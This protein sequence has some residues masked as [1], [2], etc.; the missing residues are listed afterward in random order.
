MV[1]ILFV[2]S[3]FMFYNLN[4][5]D[6]REVQ[7]ENILVDAVPLLETETLENPDPMTYLVVGDPKPELYGDIYSNIVEL[8]NR[9]GVKYGLRDDVSRMELDPESVILI[10][11]DDQ[12]GRR[13]DPRNL[14]RFI[15]EG[16]RAV[17]A[18][19]LPEGSTDSYLLPVQGII[20][21]TARV[22][23]TDFHFLRD[24]FP[25]QEERMAYDGYNMSTWITVREDATVYV[26]DGEKHTPIVYTYPYGEGE[27]LMINGTLLSDRRCSGFLT[28]GLALMQECFLYPVVGVETVYL[29]NFPLATNADD[30]NCLRLYG[31]TTEAFIRDIIWPAFQGISTRNGIPY[32]SS[33]LAY[34]TVPDS[35]PQI[36]E[37]LFSTMGK[38]AL[39]FNVEL[40]YAS[41]GNGDPELYRHDEFLDRFQSV[42]KKYRVT[43]LITTGADDIPAVADFAGESINM[44]RGSLMSPNPS[45][46]FKLGKSYCVFPRATDGIDLDQGDLLE[47]ASVYSSYGMISHS[48]DINRFVVMDE[49]Q[50]VWDSEKL[51]LQDFEKRVLRV[52]PGLEPMSLSRTVNPLRSY[53]SL[54]YGWW[55]EEKEKDPDEIHLNAKS[56]APGQP[57]MVRLSREIR[58]AQGAD[59]EKIGGQYYLVRLNQPQAVLRL[60]EGE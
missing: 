56:F 47:L 60:D 38:S 5:S 14:E 48:I 45:D 18:A 35:F 23:Y 28:S 58:S 27:T 17:F 2:C 3:V 30:A 13:I 46:R 53:L 1:V 59:Y 15:S 20:E 37:G 44:V 29:D 16:G 41:Y 4:E 51:K 33:V 34:S 11:A 19:G 54:K 8:L 50:A 40:A 55:M 25:V 32:T 57:F 22:N 31:R 21:K 49:D 6:R 12:V 42:F 24:Y 43:S 52:F 9:L 7:I 10:F 26:E 39:Q 36:S